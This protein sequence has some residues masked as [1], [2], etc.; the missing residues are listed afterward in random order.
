[1][2]EVTLCGERRRK[3]YNPTGTHALSYSLFIDLTDR[4]RLPSPSRV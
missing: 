1:M 3:M 4:G 2:S